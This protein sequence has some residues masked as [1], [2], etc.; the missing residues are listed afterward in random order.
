M[1][2]E[3]REQDLRAYDNWVDNAPGPHL[4]D[5]YYAWLAARESLRE[6]MA[7]EVIEL[8]CGDNSC[9]FAKDKGGMRTNGGCRCFQAAGFH[10][11]PTASAY[12]MLPELLRLRAASPTPT[13][14]EVLKALRSVP[15]QEGFS[16][17][18]ARTWA[19][20]LEA[21]FKTPSL[22]TPQAVEPQD[23]EADADEFMRNDRRFTADPRE[24]FLEGRRTC[25]CRNKGE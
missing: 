13:F 11:S 7:K 12:Q 23:N 8:D 1:T 22:P 21:H 3:Q 17:G 25:A 24:A 20:W 15:E 14:A 6:E 5:T 18:T 19:N 16:V 2:P 9:H 10:K 4:G